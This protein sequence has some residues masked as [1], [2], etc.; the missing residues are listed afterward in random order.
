MRN[1]LEFINK[2]NNLLLFIKKFYKSDKGIIYKI[3]E[4]IIDINNN[5]LYTYIIQ[6][7]NID[8]YQY[9]TI[10]KK[11]INDLL[12]FKNNMIPYFKLA[13]IH[14]FQKEYNSEE[15][16][17]NDYYDE[18]LKMYKEKIQNNISVNYFM[19]NE[20]VETILEFSFK[21]FEDLNINKKSEYQLKLYNIFDYKLT[22]DDVDNI[23]F[24][25]Y[26]S[27]E[28]NNEKF[29]FIIINFLNDLRN[30]IT[31]FIILDVS[32]LRLQ[33]MIINN[34]KQY[35]KNTIE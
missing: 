8:G 31:N 17:M 27:Q 1:L 25:D 6:K 20:I 16:N 9:N 23:E 33:S 35:I 30:I 19:N 11:K 32:L 18:I 7:F 2:H 26:I 22:D 14:K 34:R 21:I 3:M 15:I 12:F 4:N 13:F 28:I 29:Y 24:N 5:Y 10:I